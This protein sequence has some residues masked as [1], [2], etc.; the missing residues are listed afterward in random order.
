[1]RISRLTL[2]TLIGALFLSS[3][4]A[5]HDK[6]FDVVANNNA[7]ENKKRDLIGG[8]F[9][10]QSSQ[11]SP[12][13]APAST[14]APTQPTSNLGSPST[15]SDPTNTSTTAQPLPSLISN[16]LN[17]SPVANPTGTATTTAASMNPKRKPKSGTSSSADGVNNSNDNTD[18]NINGT[19]I[20]PANKSQDETQSSELAPGLIAVM[21]ILVLAILAAVAFSCYKIRQSQRRRRESW[22]EDILKNHAGSVGYS[23]GA[24]YGMYVG[25][26][27]F[28]KEKPDLWRKNLDLFH[29]E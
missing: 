23:K 20:Y 28:G 9:N 21:I 7:F 14:S 4:L 16:I 12:A 29:R 27:G 17:P 8:L 5:L 26:G 22:S 25:D 13:S 1:M 6:T 10:S 18:S 15:T 19:S 24:G 11:G 2:L 3:T